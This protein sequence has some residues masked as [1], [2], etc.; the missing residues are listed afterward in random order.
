M[1]TLVLEFSDLAGC[2][3]LGAALRDY[4]H[5][6]R[7]VRVHHGDALPGDLDDVDAIVMMG[8]PQNVADE[9]DWLE[10]ISALAREAHTREMP[11]LGVCLGCQ[12]LAH[13][14]GGEV[15]ALEGGPEVGFIDA[16]LNP[17]GREEPLFAGQPWK[18]KL[19][20][21]HSYEVTKLPPGAKLLASSP[22][23]KVQAWTSGLRTYG[24]QY[25]PE[26][27]VVAIEAFATDKP[28]ELRAA[29]LTIEQLDAQ[30]EE[31]YAN[32]SRLAQRLFEAIALLLMPVDRRYQGLV[33]D[34]HH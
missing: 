31:H 27:D 17:A 29:G 10:P 12:I 1:S 30:I 16:E 24:L 14:L 19:F 21:W 2:R 5:R 33:K 6:L 18:Q 32:F 23:C 3:R 8:G 11:V 28:D 34:L 9:P 15:A 7:I 25:H 22:R 13:A 20:Q 4:G 26:V